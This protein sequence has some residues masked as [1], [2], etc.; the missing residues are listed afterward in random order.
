MKSNY[1][2][3]I[4]MYSNVFPEN[5]CNHI[6]ETFEILKSEKKILNRQQTENNVKKTIKQ[7]EF[8]AICD[9]KGAHLPKDFGGRSTMDLLWEGIQSCF[10]CYVNEYS[11]LK[12]IDIFAD[13][14]IKLQKTEPGAGYHVW[15]HEQGNDAHAKRSLVYAIYLNTIT[16]AGETEFLYQKLRI[17]PQ[18]NSVLIFPA[19][20]THVHR[21]N[22]V[23]GNLSKYIATGWFHNE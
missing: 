9:T 12:D 15:H 19:S 20:H 2:Q 16:E 14:P 11:T 17:P 4:G 22:V 18:E 23:H 6:I 8:I 21:G 10:D 1:V 7:D 3:H 5:F 13:K